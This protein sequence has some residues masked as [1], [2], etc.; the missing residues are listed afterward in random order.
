MYGARGFATIR[1]KHAVTPKPLLVDPLTYE[2]I[3]HSG[4]KESQRRV[5]A[6]RQKA[7]D[8]CLLCNV[9]MA[10]FMGAVGEGRGPQ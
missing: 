3:G 10:Y 8:R 6:S 4:P 2:G 9:A 1:A 5:H 7:I